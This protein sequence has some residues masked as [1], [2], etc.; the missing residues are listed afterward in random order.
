MGVPVSMTQSATAGLVGAGA[1]TGVRRIRWQFAT[2][3]LT[4]WLVTVPASLTLGYAAGL[5]LRSTL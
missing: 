3:V 4:A 5:A 1:S 2:P